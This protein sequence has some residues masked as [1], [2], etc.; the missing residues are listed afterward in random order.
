MISAFFH[1]S[2]R[3]Y[4]NWE[5]AILLY[6]WWPLLGKLI[7]SWKYAACQSKVSLKKF[8]TAEK[9]KI[10]HKGTCPLSHG[11]NKD[12]SNI[13]KIHQKWFFLFLIILLHILE[14]ILLVLK[15]SYFLKIPLMASLNILCSDPH[16]V[17]KEAAK[18]IRKVHKKRFLWPIKN[19]QIYFISNQNLPKTFYGPCKTSPLP[20]L[21]LM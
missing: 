7:P 10:C 15:I 9:K 2:K 13:V 14:W 11:D 16:N 21:Y 19:S 17:L 5:I 18:K 20:P 6:S 1:C 8:Q 3:C 4:D 12:R